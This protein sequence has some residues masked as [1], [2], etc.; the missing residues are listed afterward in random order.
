MDYR[1]VFIGC[2]FEDFIYFVVVVVVFEVV[3][4]RFGTGGVAYLFFVVE[5]VCVSEVG[6]EVV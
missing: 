2:V 3:G 1:V 6:I 5:V 4:F